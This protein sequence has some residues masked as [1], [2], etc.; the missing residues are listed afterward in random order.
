MDLI[1]RKS[2]PDIL[3]DFADETIEIR[4]NAYANARTNMCR[5]PSI[6]PEAGKEN[7]AL[8]CHGCVHER[9]AKINCFGCIRHKSEWLDNYRGGEE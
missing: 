2:A 1:S 6:Q 4:K 5:L 7:G 3:D 8:S 9:G